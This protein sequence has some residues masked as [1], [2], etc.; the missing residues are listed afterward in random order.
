MRSYRLLSVFSKRILSGRRVYL[1]LFLLARPA[2]AVVNVEGTRVIFNSG[3]S[4]SSVNLINS[5]EMPALVQLWFDEGDIFAAPES[6]KTPLIAIPPVFR[7]QPGELRDIKLQ[8]VSRD[9]LPRDKE[10]LY[11]LNIY[12]VPPNTLSQGAAKRVILPLR[13]RM[14]VFIRP[15]TIF[16]P[17]GTDGQRL[18]FRFKDNSR[19]MIIISNP[20]P[21]YMALSTLDVGNENTGGMMLAPGESKEVTLRNVINS[22]KVQYEVVNDNGSRWKCSGQVNQDTFSSAIC[23]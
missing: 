4:V 9:K 20:S 1:I 8:L 2:F 23:S 19:K 21:W 12:Q 6:S 18:Q 10:T 13:L 15:A 11:W 22:A 17:D 7:L 16:R 14:K 3:E 5:G